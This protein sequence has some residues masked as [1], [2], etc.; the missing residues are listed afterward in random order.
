MF[1]LM[2]A[3]KL[4]LGQLEPYSAEGVAGDKA[5]PLSDASSLSGCARGNAFLLFSWVFTSADRLHVPASPFP[6]ASSSSLLWDCCGLGV[7]G[8]FLQQLFII[9]PFL[10]P[11]LCTELWD[12]MQHKELYKL[13][14][15]SKISSIFSS[16]LSE[17]QWLGSGRAGTA[18]ATGSPA[19]DGELSAVLEMQR[20]LH[21]HC[22]VHPQTSPKLLCS[23]PRLALSVPSVPP[24]P[25][26]FPEPC[27]AVTCMAMTEAPVSGS[28]EFWGL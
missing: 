16:L 6:Q 4:A 26:A 17:T 1:S 27:C 12:L 28:S 3:C 14:S 25:C 19:A 21:C 20:A 22:L 7:Q 5:L 10:K 2:E 9:S 11:A 23:P 24:R 13:F 8:V 18:A 15:T